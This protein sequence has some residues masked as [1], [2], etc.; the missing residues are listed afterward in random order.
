M[1]NFIAVPAKDLEDFLQKHSFVRGKQRDEVV[2]TR[3]S[4]VDPALHIK[5]YTS[6]RDG[7]AQVRA[8]GRDAIRVCVV[9]D[10]GQRS[11]GVGRFPP[12]FRVTS[13]QSVLERLDIRL[14]EAAQRAKDW[15]SEQ[16]AKEDAKQKALF[17]QRE[18]EQEQAAFM[19]DPDMQDPK[20]PRDPKFAA[21]A[22]SLMVPF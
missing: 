22:D 11:F 9:W 16:A 17:A 3:H 19:S 12:V 13:V 2:Y 5:V 6:I 15:L 21:Y 10:N 20:N 8:S 7:Q 18:R 14:R 1:A 4:K